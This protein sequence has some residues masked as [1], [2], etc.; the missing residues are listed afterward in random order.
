MGIASAQTVPSW[1]SVGQQ[2]SSTSPTSLFGNPSTFTAAADQQA[3]DYDRIMQNY[4]DI[5]AKNQAN[6]V[7]AERTNANLAKYSRSA[8]VSGSL[9]NLSDLAT[10]GG[11]SA[12]DIADIRSRGISPIRSVYANAQQN[13][14]RSKSLQ[15][16]YSPNYTAATAK[17][18]RGLSDAVSRGNQDINA[19]IAQNVASNRI[20]VAPMYSSAA[21]S[22]NAARTGVDL[23]NS[24]AINRSDEGNANRALE[25]QRMQ[26]SNELGAIQG[27]TSLY[28]TTP[29][30]THTFGNQVVQASQLGQGQQEL[31]QRKQATVSNAIFGHRS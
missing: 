10:S 22:E 25:A 16:G 20:A 13:I 12:G 2:R 19:G 31:N 27:Q 21:Q 7:T 29:A 28:G 5:L 30:L 1:Q 11:Y 6:P 24:D 23:R 26:Q 14:D 9:A 18:T 15:G 8:E 3:S 4:Q 17:L